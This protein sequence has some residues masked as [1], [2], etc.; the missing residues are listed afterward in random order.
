MPRQDVITDREYHLDRAAGLM[1]LARGFL[2]KAGELDMMDR[3]G[4]I[5]AEA[6]AKVQERLPAAP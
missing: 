5:Q 1:D 4:D 3:L 6:E 2:R